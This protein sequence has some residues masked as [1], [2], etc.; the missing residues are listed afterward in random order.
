MM[1]FDDRG[2]WQPPFGS[3]DVETAKEGG[4]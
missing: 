3:Y 4:R 2:A 1:N